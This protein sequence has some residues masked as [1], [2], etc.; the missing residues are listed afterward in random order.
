MLLLLATD[1]NQGLSAGEAADRLGR[2]GPNLLP[3][4][5]RMK[6]V[7][8]LLNQLRHPLIYV[9]LVA[10]AVTLVLREYSDAAVIFGVV[11]INAV[12]GY[13]QE[14]KAEAALD[15]L[16]AMVRTRARVRRDGRVTAIESAELV[17]GDIVLLQAGDKVPADLRLLAAT[18]LAVDESTL[19][20]ESVPVEKDEVVIDPDLPVADRRNMAHAG[21]LV[22]TGTGTGV[23]VATGADTEMG[24][25]HRLVGSAENLATPLTRKLAWFSK[26]LTVVILAL[27]AMRDV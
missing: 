3:E 1:A 24:Q 8:R 4:T 19:T 20:G 5:H 11:I 16:R 26:V 25:V 2:Y 10:G 12:I 21:T 13:F 7:V 14:S 6:P 17:P 18:E 27:A 22:A 23:V 15:A 9:L